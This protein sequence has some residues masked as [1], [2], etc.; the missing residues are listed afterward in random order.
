MRKSF[1]ITLPVL[2]VAI[3]APSA[4]A[5]TYTPI[6]T[7]TGCSGTCALPTALDVTFPTPTTIEITYLGLS[8]LVSIPSGLPG[9]TYAWNADIEKTIDFFITDGVTTTCDGVGPGHVS[10]GTLTFAAVATPEPNSAG[11]LVAGIGLLLVMRRR[12]DQGLPQAS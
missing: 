7:T 1:W 6:F 11:L 3:G 4:H 2:L 10:C 9:D 8:D 5:D 12:I